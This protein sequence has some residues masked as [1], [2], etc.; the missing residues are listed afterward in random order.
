MKKNSKKPS[1][2]KS[3]ENEVIVAVTMLYV[4][5]VTVMVIVHY[6]Q[7][8]AQKTA[9]SSTSASHSNK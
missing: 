1:F 7:P 2:L 9:T 6:I 4:I 5:I 3:M 8:T